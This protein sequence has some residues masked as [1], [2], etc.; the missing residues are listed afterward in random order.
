MTRSS[1][2]NEPPSDPGR[3]TAPFITELNNPS[4][5][6]RLTH[7]CRAKGVDVTSIWVHSD[8]DTM[9]EYIEQRDAP[10]DGWKLSNWDEYAAGLNTEDPPE[11]HTSPSTTA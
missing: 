7:R 5:L 4:W 10:R 2:G 6:P 9:R 3:F 8:I 11:P 1:Q